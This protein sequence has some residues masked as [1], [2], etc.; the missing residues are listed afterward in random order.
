MSA[1]FLGWE[2]A[3]VELFL[4]QLASYRAGEPLANVVDKELGFVTA[5]PRPAR[6]PLG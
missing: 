1:D 3:L 6:R 2:Q 5:G 4:R